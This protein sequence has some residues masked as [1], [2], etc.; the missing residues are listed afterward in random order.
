MRGFVP[1]LMKRKEGEKMRVFLIVLDSLGIGHA[2]DAKEFGDEGANTLQSVSRSPF[3]QAKNLCQLGL[4][5]IDTV[6]CCSKI[7]AKGSYGRAKELSKGKDTT[8]GHWEM[9]GIVSKTAMPTYPKGFPNEI[10]KEFEKRTGRTILCNRPISGTEAI[11][12][13]GKE[14]VEKGALIV[15]TS[16]D[17]VFQIAAHEEV[18]PIDKLYEY[19]QIA[20]E[21]LVG[22]HSVGR[23]IARPF[24]G[25]EGSYKRTANRH[26]F[27]LSP[28]K[29]TMLNYLTDNGFTT[30]GIGKIKDIFAGSG[31]EHSQSSQNNEEGMEQTIALLET[32]FEGICFTNL[33]D[34][35]ML[36]G[37]RNDIDGYAKAIL[38]FDDQLEVF[39]KKMKDEDILM[40][41]A[42]H[43]CDPGYKGTDHTREC[44]PI[45]VCGKQIKEGMNIGTRDTYADIAATI[46]EC[47]HV[48]GDIDGQSFYREIMK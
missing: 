36:Y 43:G 14:Q 24:K 6:E 10:I 40:I 38:R 8:I 17:S 44:V 18:I 26:D 13:F 37:H 30:Y 33:V 46:L 20:R 31:I 7:E 28:P 15:Y 4:G 2:P 9:A 21:I 34:F 42:D 45:L 35:D 19:C 47:F 22:E 5:E 27:S 23:V 39:L 41:T 32:E 16:A 25:I 1:Y 29:K 48:E 3:F 11:D 12:I